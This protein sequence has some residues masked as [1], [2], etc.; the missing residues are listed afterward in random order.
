MKDLTHY[1][2]LSEMLRY[3]DPEM[4]YKTDNWERIVNS[5]GYHLL[6]KL[7]P[8]I[9]HI[10]T[11]P[12]AVQE[13]YY[14]G[15]FDVQPV[16]TLDIGYILFGQD[17][18]RGGFMVNLKKE[19]IKAMNDCGSELPDHLPN[20]LNLLPKIEPIVA[21]ELIYSL[22]IPALHEMILKFRNGDNLYKAL[23]E[24]IVAVMEKDYP[25]SSFEKFEFKTQNKE[26]AFSVR[27]D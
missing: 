8:F 22:L 21:E 23:L 19:H 5:Y 16:C 14:T 3:P 7:Q 10:R 26:K 13:E 12:I 27:M 15:T 1:R 11:Q 6:E 17:Y 20:I 24:I 2:Y 4:K 9:V 18:R 25:E